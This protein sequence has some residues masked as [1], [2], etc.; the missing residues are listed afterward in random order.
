MVSR[1]LLQ[2]KADAPLGSLL[3]ADIRIEGSDHEWGVALASVSIRDLADTATDPITF[4][5]IAGHSW[6]GLAPGAAAGGSGSGVGLGDGGG[7]QSLRLMPAGTTAVS[8]LAR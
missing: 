7:S 2:V 5:P 6:L 3:R 1:S 8:F 4:I